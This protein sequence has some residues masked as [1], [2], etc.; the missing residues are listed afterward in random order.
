MYLCCGFS[1]NICAAV[2]MGAAVTL[3][4]LLSVKRVMVQDPTDCHATLFPRWLCS[5]P[6]L[7]PPWR[8]CFSRTEWIESSEAFTVSMHI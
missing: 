4:V 8:C 6:H 5:L 1:L 2:S 3:K 7:F